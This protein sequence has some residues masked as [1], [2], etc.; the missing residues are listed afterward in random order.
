MSTVSAGT[1]LPA[2]GDRTSPALE[3]RNLRV[4]YANGALGIEDVSLRVEEGQITALFGSNGAGKT[5]SVRAVTGFLKTEG[6]RVIAGTVHSFGL[7]LTNC[8][9]SASAAVGVIQVPERNKVFVNLT[10]AEN[11]VAIGKLPPKT[12]RVEVYEHIHELFPI[13]MERRKQLAGRLSG[14]QQQM[15]AI[16]R[17]LACEP[18]VLIVD[19]MTLGL[20]VSLHEPLFDVVKR[21]AA[22]GTSVVIVDESTRFALEVAD[23]CYLLNSGSIAAEGAVEVFRDTDVLASG[24]LG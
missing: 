6:A 5:T 12:R 8:E 18:K 3:A 4:R 10:V 24:Y 17:A 22:S 7:D 20:H 2:P 16:A 14:G 1:P 15:L 13:L 23:Y 9:P 21:V 11:L 19:E